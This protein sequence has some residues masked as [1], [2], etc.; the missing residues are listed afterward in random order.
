MRLPR[1]AAVADS[2]EDRPP[3]PLTA[4]AVV[5]GLALAGTSAAITF[6]STASAGAAVARAL[7]VAVPVAV[8]A[9]AVAPPTQRS[10]RL[11]PHAHRLRLVP[12]HAVGVGQ[13]AGLQHRT[14]SGLGARGQPHLPRPV[15]PH[16][17]PHRAASTA[18]SCGPASGC[19]RAVPA[20]RAS[21]RQVPLALPGLELRPP[22]PR[23]RVHGGRVG[24]GLGGRGGP[25]A[26]RDADAAALRGG[27]GAPGRAGATRH[28]APAAHAQPRPG[29]R[30]PPPRRAGGGDRGPGGQPRHLSRQARFPGWRRSPSRR[31]PRASGSA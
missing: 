9:Y 7:M 17:P 26:A 11:A 3:S 6:E 1:V 15:V 2:S 30:D 19:R 31:W 24:A 18:R 16:R 14:R 20:L 27:P 13:R 4:A 8:G 10:L 29:R 12:H 22:V 28:P 23:Q 25:A 21:Q 5:A